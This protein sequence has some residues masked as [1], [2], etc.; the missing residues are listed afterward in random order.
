MSVCFGASFSLRMGQFSNPVATHPRT[1]EFE[2]PPGRVEQNL[3]HLGGFLHF[4]QKVVGVTLNL[5]T[6][7]VCFTLL[8][9]LLIS[10]EAIWE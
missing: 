5:L 2:V 9:Q 7:I 1:N 3:L 6:C 8:G 10:I 4:S